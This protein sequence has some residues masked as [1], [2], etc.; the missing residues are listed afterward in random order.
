AEAAP[1]VS[2]PARS[3]EDARR[4]APRRGT[5]RIMGAATLDAGSAG[6][7]VHRVCTIP[8][9]VLLE[10]DALAVV[11]LVLRRDVVAPL[12][13]LALEGDLD[14][15]FV[16]RHWGSPRRT[17]TARG[18]GSDGQTRTVDLSIMSR[19][20]RPTDLGLRAAAAPKATW[21]TELPDRIELSTSSLPWKRSAD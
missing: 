10:L 5:A 7:L 15:L 4:R 19:A 21:R 16:L 1:F 20:P 18:P 17:R 6:L 3:V 2:G 8:T 12:A 14:A 9:A 11:E 13:G